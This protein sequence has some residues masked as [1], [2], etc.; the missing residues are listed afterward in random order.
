MH[1]IE[2]LI[3][4]ATVLIVARAHLPTAVICPLPQGFALIPVSG[5][6]HGDLRKLKFDSDATLPRSGDI[7]PG[8]A[9]LAKALSQDGPT[10]YVATCIH[11][12]TGYQDAMVWIDGELALNLG[13]TEDDMARWP[14]SPI[15]CALR[16]VGVE[17]A[18]S[19]DE[20]DAL[21][22]GKC[23]SNE[24]WEAMMSFDL[25]VFELSAAPKT[26]AEFIDWYERQAELSKAHGDDDP[27]VAS[28]A[29]QRWFAE[30]IQYFP[31][32]D[33]PFATDEGLENPA[34]TEYRI[35]REFI[36]S[37]FRSS[38]AN[39]AR[40]KMRELAIKHGVGFFNASDDDGEILVPGVGALP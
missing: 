17:A 14:N 38:M 8:L 5:P 20:F 12:G 30:M 37:E 7:A 35:G 24:S 25:M 29:L 27:S 1:H 2:A 6:V 15:S 23:S 11:G 40:A 3:A 34:L 21:G 32:L 18:D 19:E 9:A 36:Y 16:Y 4:P 28:P 31:P 13:D 33:G 10:L 39:A 26:R 22:L